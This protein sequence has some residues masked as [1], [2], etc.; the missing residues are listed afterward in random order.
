MPLLVADGARLMCGCGTNPSSLVLAPRPYTADGLMLAHVEDNVPLANVQPFGMC[1]TMANPAVAAATAAAQ[2][3]LTPQ[4]CVPMLP[5]PW[6]GG[7]KYLSQNVP[8]TRSLPVLTN[9]S[10]L[11]CAYTGRIQVIE[12][13]SRIQID[14]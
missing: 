5:M 9:Q 11:D 13:A 10:T 8:P 1:T 12:P 6:N 14:G 7:S 3:V 4:P 2:G